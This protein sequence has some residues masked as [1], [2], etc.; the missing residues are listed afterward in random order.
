M[1]NLTPME[2]AEL[3]NAAINE[4][5]TEVEQDKLRRRDAR[6]KIEDMNMLKKLGLSEGDLCS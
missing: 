1:S 3:A 6:S 5:K 4:M 2:K